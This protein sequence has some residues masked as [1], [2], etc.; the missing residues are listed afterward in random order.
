MPRDV[1]SSATALRAPST[2]TDAVYPLCPSRMA[3]STAAIRCGGVW[4]PKGIGSPMFRYRT[5]RPVASTFRAS[6]TMLRM[7]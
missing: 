7:A 4:N 6:A 1:Y 5:V 2:P 3:F